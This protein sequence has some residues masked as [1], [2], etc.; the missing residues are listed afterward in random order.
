MQQGIKEVIILLGIITITN[1]V[2]KQ[3]TKYTN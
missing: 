1:Y 2:I 3:G